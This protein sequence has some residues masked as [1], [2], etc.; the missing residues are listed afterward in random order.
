M[1]PFIVPR[2]SKESWAHEGPLIRT[3]MFFNTI[4]IIFGK[5]GLGLHSEVENIR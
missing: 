3:T 1:F 4:T 5:M 2:L